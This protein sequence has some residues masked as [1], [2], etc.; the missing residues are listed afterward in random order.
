MSIESDP[1]KTSIV[2]VSQPTWGDLVAEGKS[3]QV[4]RFWLT[5]RVVTFPASEFCRWERITAE[6]ECIR[7]FTAKEEI[8]IE[9]RDLTEV[10]A[11]LDLGRVCELHANFTASS[12]RRP[13]P[14]IARI[15]IQP[16]GS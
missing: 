10:G 8:V 5:D 7:L 15:T 13:G 11:A 2:A 16:V 12:S 6:P 3:A 4:I 9:G 1:A 14:R